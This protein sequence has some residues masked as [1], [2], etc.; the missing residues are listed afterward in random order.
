MAKQKNVSEAARE[1]SIN[2]GD[3][4]EV[5]CHLFLSNN[6]FYVTPS[7]PPSHHTTRGTMINV[8]IR[9]GFS[10]GL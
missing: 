7:T 1:L 6:R 3:V 10:Q 2:V 4:L 9:I 5:S 8:V